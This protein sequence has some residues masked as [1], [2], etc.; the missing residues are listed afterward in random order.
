[1]TSWHTREQSRGGEIEGVERKGRHRLNPSAGR[2]GA[3]SEAQLN[4]EW[5]THGY[6]SN[7]M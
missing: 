4:V 3:E 1:M 2:A 7:R 5:L 6:R